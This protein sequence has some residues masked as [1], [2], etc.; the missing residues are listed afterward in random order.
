VTAAVLP[1]LIAELRGAGAELVR[2]DELAS[3]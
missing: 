2:L 1:R 3:P